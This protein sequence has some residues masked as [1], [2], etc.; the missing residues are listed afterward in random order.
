LR[1]LSGPEAWNFVSFATDCEA[2]N[3]RHKMQATDKIDRLSLGLLRFARNDES[4][5]F[6]F[7][8]NDSVVFF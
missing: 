6:R 5:D 1:T 2:L 4:L 8:G 7:R 3:T